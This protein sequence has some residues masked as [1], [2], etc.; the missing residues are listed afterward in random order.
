MTV[1][2]K[3]NK[4]K[5][6]NTGFSMV[7]VLISMAIFALLITPIVSGIIS[8]LKMSNNSKT[9][10]YRNDFAQNVMEYVKDAPISEIMSGDYVKNLGTDSSSIYTTGES[11]DTASPGSS[12]VTDWTSVAPLKYT[13]YKDADKKPE[14]MI[15]KELNYDTYTMSGKI[16]LG[17]AT[18]KKDYAYVLEISNKEYAENEQK[19]KNMKTQDEADV[20][21]TDVNNLATSTVENLDYTKVALINGTFANYDDAAYQ[22]MYT[23]KL[24][25][26]KQ[27]APER[28]EQILKGQEAATTFASD[29]GIRIITVRVYQDATSKEYVVACYLTYHDKSLVATE[30][31]KPVSDYLND[32]VYTVYATSF[33]ELPNI[34]LMYNA[35]IYNK[36]YADEDYIVFDT[37]GLDDEDKANFFV[38][39]TAETYSQDVTDNADATVQGIMDKTGTDL[40]RNESATNKS[41]EDVEIFMLK[42]KDS[43]DFSVYTNF[44]EDTK[45]NKTNT[46]VY[47]KASDL[48]VNSSNL[49]DTG[50]EY[51]FS[52]GKYSALNDGNETICTGIAEDDVKQLQNSQDARVGLYTVKLWMEEGDD[53][54]A[55]RNKIYVTQPD[56]TKKLS[57]EPILKG[58]KGGDLLND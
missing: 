55:L 18:G 52:F 11:S 28:Y 3:M 51:K 15:E 31:N 34:Y 19:V 5:Q 58:T 48:S 36:D 50:G 47:Y 39:E 1:W 2:N 10:Q 42:S 12:W 4:G 56:G 20:L 29:R 43:K 35:C 30:S 21:Y 23:Q 54:T 16:E 57:L 45:V 8:S 33:S 27:Y 9:L 37:S 40:Y 25:V 38:V 13:L 17:S 49:N 24:Q 14:E 41:R 32:I 6:L 46:K 44:G 22:A 53:P 26:L 7:E